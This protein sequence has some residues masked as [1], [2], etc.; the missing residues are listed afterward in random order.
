MINEQLSL[1][2]DSFM[3]QLV[4]FAFESGEAVGGTDNRL[5]ETGCCSN[6]SRFRH[7]SPSQLARSLTN[8]RNE[9]NWGENWHHWSTGVQCT[10]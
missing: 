1:S 2:L 9:L 10:A 6:L 3:N 8:V 4:H 5:C 7:G